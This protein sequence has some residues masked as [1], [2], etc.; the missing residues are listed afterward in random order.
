MVELSYKQQIPLSKVL[1]ADTYGLDKNS[2]Y[3]SL[4]FSLLDFFDCESFL[5]QST[6]RFCFW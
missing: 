3:F 6:L 2:R 1:L 4:H 5:L